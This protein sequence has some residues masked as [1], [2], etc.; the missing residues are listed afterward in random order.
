MFNNMLKL[1]PDKTEF[2]F[3]GNSIQLSQFD[4]IFPIKLLGNDTVSSKS[5]RNLGVIFDQEF[6]FNPHITA[7]CKS[8]NYHMRDFRRVRK[9]PDKNTAIALGNALVSSR[10]DYCNSLLYG[11]TAKE[12]NRLQR[13]QN[14]LCRIITHTSSFAHITPHLKSLHWLP[15]KYRIDFKINQ[16]EICEASSIEN[17]WKKLKACYF[18]Q[19]FP[20]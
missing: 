9:Y 19:A 20:A 6:N 7:V 1:N 11:I 5:V 13:V 4:N 12:I 18:G 8:C 10:L 2:L 14:S 3:I 16:L 17:F 15:V